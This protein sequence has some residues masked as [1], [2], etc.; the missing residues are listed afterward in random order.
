M[1]QSCVNPEPALSALDFLAPLSDADASMYWHNLR[2]D[3]FDP[4]PLMSLFVLGRPASSAMEVLGT[5][6]LV[7]NPQPTLAKL[8]SIHN[9]LVLPAERGHGL[10]DRLM[11]HVESFALT[12]LDMSLLLLDVA[13]NTPERAFLLRAGWTEF[14]KRP[15]YAPYA[16]GELGQCSFFHKKLGPA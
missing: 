10:G 15:D 7:R 2:L 3:L 16:D 8:A 5:V 13:T 4:N 9:L 14:G 1:L 12:E 11:A 6:Q